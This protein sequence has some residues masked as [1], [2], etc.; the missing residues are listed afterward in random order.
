MDQDIPLLSVSLKTTVCTFGISFLA[1]R[2]SGI[3]THR[4]P[5]EPFQQ[6]LSLWELRAVL[7]GS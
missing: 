6:S 1:F 7:A 3:Y 5:T 2:Q 4:P